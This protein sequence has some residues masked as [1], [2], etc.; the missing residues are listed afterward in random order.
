MKAKINTTTHDVQIAWELAK[1]MAELTGNEFRVKDVHRSKDSMHYIITGEITSEQF[2]EMKDIEN[3]WVFYDLTN[4]W[5]AKYGKKIKS[6]YSRREHSLEFFYNF[7]KFQAECYIVLVSGD[8]EEH[9]VEYPEGL[10]KTT[11]LVN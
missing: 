2:D 4:G 9:E 11:L 6:E 7:Y 10:A 5:V 8:S 3:D 1:E